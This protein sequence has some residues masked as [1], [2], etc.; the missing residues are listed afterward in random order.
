M[1][2]IKVYWI[3]YLEQQGYESTKSILGL[4]CDLEVFKQLAK[5]KYGITS[6]PIEDDYLRGSLHYEYSIKKSDKYS[7]Y[8]HLVAEPTQLVTESITD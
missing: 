2:T 4:V 1:E 7:E 8:Y 3:V 6:E 5:N